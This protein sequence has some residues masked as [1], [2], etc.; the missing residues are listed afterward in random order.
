MNEPDYDP[1]KDEE[2]L[3][4]VK[5]S[6]WGIE[7]DFILNPKK[8]TYESIEVELECIVYIQ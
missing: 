4:R 5:E 2:M 7:L 3:N 8:S 1:F 6:K